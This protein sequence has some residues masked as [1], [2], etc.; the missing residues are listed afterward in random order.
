MTTRPRQERY[1]EVEFLSFESTA[2]GWEGEGNYLYHRALAIG[3]RRR[4]WSA[5]FSLLLHI[6]QKWGNTEK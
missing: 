6:R 2:F 5:N 1:R 4:S 3:Q